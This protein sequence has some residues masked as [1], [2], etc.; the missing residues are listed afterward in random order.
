MNRPKGTKDIYGNMQ[1]VREYVENKIEEISTLNNFKKIETPVFEFSNVYKKSVGETSDIVLKEMYLFNDK[2]GREMVLRPEGTAGTIRA[3]VENKLFTNSLP[4]KYY[5][6]GPMFRYERPQKGRQ[7]QFT[8]FGVEMISEKS[9]Y[10]DA[11]I[12]LFAHS[13]LNSLNIKSKLILNSLGDSETR[14][15]YSKELKKYFSNYKDKL[16][17]DSVERIEKNPLRILD[18][19]IDGTKD[20][21]INAP[22]ISEFYTPEIR[23]YFLMLTEFLEQSNIDFEIDNKLVRG[24]DYYAD[25]SFEFVSTSGNAGSQSTLIG[26][27]RYD[28]LLSNFGGPGLSGIGFAIGIE[29]IINELHVDNVLESQKKPIDIFV[30]N[31]SLHS[32]STA[33]NLVHNLRKAKYVTEWNSKIYKLQKGFKL[34][35]RYDSKIKIIVG[36]KE[37]LDKSVVVNYN[38]SKVKVKIDEL[39]SY[40]KGK[41]ENNEEHK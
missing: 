2:K 29:R 24:L 12:I 22:K 36:E 39:I 40:L 34:A 25:T 35:D 8:Q 3:I 15:N 31:L 13:I 38:G 30:I 14:N 37:M 27:G 19:K 5:Y 23:E 33:L 28:K 11:E 41:L 9:P 26:G 10:V 17:N 4:L 21:V 6:Y 32:Q 20:F 1:I 16:T 18:D 7:R